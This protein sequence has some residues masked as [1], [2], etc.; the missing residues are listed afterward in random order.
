ML[1]ALTA[2]ALLISQPQAVIE[3]SEGRI[4]VALN[5]T[6]APVTVANFIAH[7]EAG[8]FD[9]GSFYRTVRDDNEREGIAPMNLIQGGHSFDGLADA[10][11]IAHE[12][13]LETGLTHDRGAISMARDGVGTA[14]TEFFIMVNDY[15]GLDAGPDGRNPDEAGYAVFGAVTEGMDVV[16]R[17]WMSPASLERAP[18]D[19]PYPQFISEPIRIETVRILDETQQTD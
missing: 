4:V 6:A 1:T 14:T 12:S 10:E 7:A 9:D 5:E 13:T 8:N 17:I 2:A 11:G 16:E 19:F 15:P 18:A 3:T